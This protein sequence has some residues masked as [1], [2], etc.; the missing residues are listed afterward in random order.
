MRSTHRD[1]RR[2]VLLLS[3]T[4]CFFWLLFT[5]GLVGLLDLLLLGRDDAAYIFHDVRVTGILR[6]RRGEG[7]E[8]KG[9]KGSVEWVSSL[10]LLSA[11]HLA[12]TLNDGVL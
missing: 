5:G 6:E 9:E 8:G 1:G 3:L 12:E 2:V 7:G 4:I 11:H 10:F